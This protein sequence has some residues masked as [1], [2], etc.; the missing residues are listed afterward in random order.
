ML[1]VWVWGD[2]NGFMV[3]IGVTLLAIVL[4]GCTLG[5]MLPILLRRVGLDPATSS[6]PFIATLID[7][8]GIVLYFSVAKLVLAEALETMPVHP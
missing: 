2:G 6:T 4:L 5:A 8:L 7:L 3:T 1:R